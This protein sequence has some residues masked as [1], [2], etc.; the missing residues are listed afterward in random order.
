MIDIF[1]IE[2]NGWIQRELVS[3]SY[4]ELFKFTHF[5]IGD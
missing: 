5:T 1:G 3:E 2:E 4:N